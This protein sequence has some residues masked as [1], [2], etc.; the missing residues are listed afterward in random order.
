VASH[1]P[2]PR[3]SAPREPPARSLRPPAPQAPREPHARPLQPWVPREP[4][5]TPAT[6]QAS[7][8]GPHR[9][10]PQE[11]PAI[12]VGRMKCPTNKK[13]IKYIKW[14]AIK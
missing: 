6:F 14:E 1:Q 8:A 10:K 5:A 11:R 9:A 13:M 12:R 3:H 4:W 2:R 7:P